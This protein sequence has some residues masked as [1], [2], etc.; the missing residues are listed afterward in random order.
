MI[1]VVTGNMSKFSEAKQILDKYGI[2]AFHYNAETKERGETLAEI[3]QD[4]ARQAF[5]KVQEPLIAEDTGMFF[6]SIPDFP[7][8]LTKRI[9]SLIGYEGIF[10]LLE[11]KGRDAF[12][13]TC[14]CYTDGSRYE[15]FEGVLKGRITNMVHSGGK[16]GLPYDRIFI[17]HGQGQTTS[18]MSDD[19][20][21]RIS[22][23]AQALKRFAEWYKTISK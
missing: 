19:E 3:V 1:V 20:K 14:V 10:R 22:H 6:E 13:K 21:G 8:I 4:K 16:P 2:D 5:E 9:F 12:F 11:G 7:G 23:R 15:I 18:M 17:P